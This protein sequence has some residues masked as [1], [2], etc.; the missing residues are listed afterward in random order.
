MFDLVLY[1]YRKRDL[2]L[3]KHKKC[4][5][6]SY[7]C[8]RFSIRIYILFKRKKS[9]S[10]NL[11]ISLQGLKKSSPSASLTKKRSFRKGIFTY[12]CHIE[13]MVMFLEHY[14]KI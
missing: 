9:M 1:T 2:G 8:N 3:R 7:I 10:F 6:S 14:C 5:F 4:S 13:K 12:D 11:G